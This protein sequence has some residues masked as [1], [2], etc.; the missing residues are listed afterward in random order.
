[1]NYKTRK[2]RRF[3]L[4]AATFF[5]FIF[6]SQGVEAQCV[7]NELREKWRARRYEEVV[8]QLQDCFDSQSE[9]LELNYMLAKTWC[10]L[11]RHKQT[12][13]TLTRR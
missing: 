2:L 13:A 12:A 1:M 8:R 5:S 10:N 11:S 6:V 7:S 4:S 9:S 3:V